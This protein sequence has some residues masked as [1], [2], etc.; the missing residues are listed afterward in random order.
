MLLGARRAL[1]KPAAVVAAGGSF[2]VS[3]TDS[4]SSGSDL[5]SYTF[6]NIDLGADDADREIFVC[7]GNRAAAT[8][9][10][11]TSL[12]VDSN[13]ATLVDQYGGIPAGASGTWGS[14]WQI[15][16][17]SGTSKD[18][19]VNCAAACSRIGIAVYRVVGRGAAAIQVGHNAS[20]ALSTLTVPTDGACISLQY[21]S[22]ACTFSN[23][24]VT[25]DAD[26]T[27]EAGQRFAAGHATGQGGSTEF[28]IT[29]SAASLSVSINIAFGP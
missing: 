14:I 27:P 1:L 19:V 20:N 18:I 17:P 3:F 4:A 13:S 23:T 12:T 15:A 10:S 26:L 6:S 2:S 16:Y 9:P 24:V 29:N 7:V 8:D 5:S 25:I 11:V 28:G 21:N 22:Q